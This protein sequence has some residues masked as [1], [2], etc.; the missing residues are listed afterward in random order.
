M[1]NVKPTKLIQN[2]KYFFFTSNNFYKIF[3]IILLKLTRQQISK[4][5][6]LGQWVVSN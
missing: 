6:W 3:E 2:L 4:L 5:N 1:K